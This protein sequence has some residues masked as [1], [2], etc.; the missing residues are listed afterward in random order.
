LSEREGAPLDGFKKITSR[1]AIQVCIGYSP[2]G[3]ARHR[4][5]SIKGIDPNAAF[6]KLAAFVRDCV[7]PVLA[8]PITK[9]TLVTKIPKVG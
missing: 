7:A 2:S 9:V 1:L 6:S 8:C 3:K 4:T 5:F